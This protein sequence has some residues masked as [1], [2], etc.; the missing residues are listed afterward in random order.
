MIRSSSSSLGTWEGA[1]LSSEHAT[2]EDWA[3]TIGIGSATFELIAENV[4]PLQPL[5]AECRDGA[6]AASHETALLTDPAVGMIAEPDR[7]EFIP[8]ASHE[9]L[10]ADRTLRFSLSTIISEETRSQ[11]DLS[12]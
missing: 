8:A 9:A 10:P 3:L 1:E 4:P 2:A 12:A 5:V 6:Q 11:I 7:A